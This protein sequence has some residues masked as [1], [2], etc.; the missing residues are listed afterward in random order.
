M[1]QHAEQL[2]QRPGYRK[3]NVHEQAHKPRQTVHQHIGLLAEQ[4]LWSD[5]GQQE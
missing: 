3:K 2:L 1:R 5:F 4:I